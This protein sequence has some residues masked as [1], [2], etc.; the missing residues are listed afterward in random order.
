MN[1]GGRLGVEIAKKD[2]NEDGYAQKK[3]VVAPRKKKKKKK[4]S[5]DGG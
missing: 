4:T 1:L 5:A 2:R 3:G